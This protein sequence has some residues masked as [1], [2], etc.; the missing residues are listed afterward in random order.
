MLSQSKSGVCQPLLGCNFNLIV[1]R[2]HGQSSLWFVVI[3]LGMAL[4]TMM[5]TVKTSKGQHITDQLWATEHRSASDILTQNVDK[6]LMPTAVKRKGKKRN[7]MLFGHTGS[8]SP[9]RS[10]ALQ[11][12][13]QR[14]F[15]ILNPCVNI[16]MLNSSTAT[17][18]LPAPFG[19]QLMSWPGH[20]AMPL[21][22]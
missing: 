15:S 10:R 19:H 1:L 16:T 5:N 14:K 12:F 4:M 21:I 7:T 13:L 18:H 22:H 6:S 11:N 8:L 3:C 20:P 9:P 17:L 2:G